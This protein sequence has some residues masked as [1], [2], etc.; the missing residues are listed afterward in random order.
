MHR[1]AK[2]AVFS[3]IAVG[4]MVTTFCYAGS[5]VMV[6]VDVSVSKQVPVEEIHHEAWDRLLRKHVD[7]AGYV[8]YTQW[9]ASAADQKLL[10]DY[11][12]HLSAAKISR[13]S[14]RE[15]QLAFWI[16]AYN[17]LT[18]KGILREY[19]TSSIRNHTAKV[20]GYNIW[21]DLQLLVAGKPYSLETIEHEILRKMNEPRIHFAIV[22]AS[23][24]CPRLLNEAYV[25][26]RLDEQLTMNTKNFFADRSKF[27]ADTK[28]GVIHVS[29]ILDWFADDFGKNSA[30]QLQ[31]IAPYVPD[32][33]QRLTASGKARVKYLD[34]DWSLN[35]QSRR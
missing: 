35:D 8:D 7:K 21:K 23:I 11:L 5:A 3:G 32:S 33:A 22:C 16:N 26:E 25:A 1:Y 2:I 10:D 27:S 31:T 9:K 24:G 28:S 18:V 14:S 17:A 30:E 34:Y 20:V 29:P 6:G 19:P 15:S 4:I 13:N 12:N